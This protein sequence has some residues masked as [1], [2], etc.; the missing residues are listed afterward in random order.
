MDNDKKES[1]NILPMRTISVGINPNELAILSSGKVYGY[2]KLVSG[3]LKPDSTNIL[4]VEF[5]S[6]SYMDCHGVT[7]TI[8]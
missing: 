2:L 5:V 8:N 7:H 1:I 6:E 3:T 4:I